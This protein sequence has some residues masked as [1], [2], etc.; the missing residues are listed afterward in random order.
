MCVV[1]QRT[2]YWHWN[3]W[4]KNQVDLLSLDII[5]PEM[6]G[7]DCLRR[8]TKMNLRLRTILLS[9]L[10]DDQQIVARL[11]EEFPRVALLSKP[12]TAE[13]LEQA[14]RYLVNAGSAEVLRT[15]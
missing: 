9:C 15:A 10:L 7:I 5:M 13:S 2:A 3:F 11:Q 1:K 4:K 14:L 12:L 8:I 6:N